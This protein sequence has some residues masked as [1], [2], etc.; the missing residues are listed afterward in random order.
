MKMQFPDF[1]DR[2]ANSLIEFKQFQN[3]SGKNSNLTTQQIFARQLRTVKGLGIENCATITRVFKTPF[4]LRQ[5]YLQ[6]TE[7]ARQVANLLNAG[8]LELMRNKSLFKEH[9]VAPREAEE[10]GPTEAQ[11]PKTVE[12]VDRVDLGNV[13][14]TAQPKL[15]NKSLKLFET[16]S[17]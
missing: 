10:G 16:E 5:C 7:G 14:V 8:K 9:V 1:E 4:L 3:E 12:D 2:I 6:C 11:L 15:F 17:S 13:V